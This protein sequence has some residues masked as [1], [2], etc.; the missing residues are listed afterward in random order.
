L[1]DR[2]MYLRIHRFLPLTR[3]EGPGV[4]ACIW[5]Q[6]C[7]IRCAGCAVP[8]T[9]SEDAGQV[10]STDDLAA[11]ILSGPHVEGVTF[12]GGE[13][14]A[15]ASALAEIGKKVKDAGLSVVTFTGYLLEEIRADHRTGWLDLLGVTDLLIDGPFMQELADVSRPWVGSSNQRYHF[16][17]D[18]YRSLSA[19]MASI[20]NR[21]EV[22]L[23]ADGKILVNGMAS[24]ADLKQL[25]HAIAEPCR[26]DEECN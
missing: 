10:A 17:T 15:Q 3:V 12:V 24:H 9:W 6:G 22:R 16:L 23:Q 1:I 21:L 5:V 20:P 26:T 14:F 4:R 2:T 13:P 25:F 18:R 19:E 8:R 11:R 7:P